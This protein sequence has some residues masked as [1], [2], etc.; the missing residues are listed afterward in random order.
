MSWFHFETRENEIK[1]KKRKHTLK[2]SN[3]SKLFEIYSSEFVVGRGG[4]YV[5]CF[6]HFS[7]FNL[8][9]GQ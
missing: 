7:A 9:L 4:E 1:K 3:K 2:T 5:I 8:V 6:P